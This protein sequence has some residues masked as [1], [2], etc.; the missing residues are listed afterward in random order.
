MKDIL[1]KHGLWQMVA[2]T[3]TVGLLIVLMILVWKLPENLA[4]VSAFLSTSAS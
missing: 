1:E 4:A 2:A 3:W